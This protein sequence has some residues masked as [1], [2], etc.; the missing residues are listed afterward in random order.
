[1]EIPLLPLEPDEL[2][3]PELV[4]AGGAP[5]LAQELDRAQVAV[6]RR[7]VLRLDLDRLERSRERIESQPATRLQLPFARALDERERIEDA[8]RRLD[9]RAR[10]PA[11][12]R[13]DEQ[14]SRAVRGPLRG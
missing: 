13:L 9:R 1:M 2:A 5:V 7:F 4:A 11:A 12:R 8:R 6:G 10:G 14:E 3:S